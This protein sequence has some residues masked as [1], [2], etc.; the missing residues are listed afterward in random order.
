MRKELILD[1]PLFF[2]L[3]TDL[4]K[5]GVKCPVPVVNKQ[6]NLSLIIMEK[7]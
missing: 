7:S 4:N 6:K 2:W 3:M 1:P 5:A